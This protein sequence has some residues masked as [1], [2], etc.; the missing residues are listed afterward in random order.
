MAA[1]LVIADTMVIRNIKVMAM[2]TKVMVIVTKVMAIVTK[3]TAIVTVV[4][5]I[6]VDELHLENIIC[7]DIFE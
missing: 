3:V 6:E 2:A 1:T 7:S 5:A 4:I